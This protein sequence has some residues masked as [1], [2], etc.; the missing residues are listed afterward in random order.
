MD[1]FYPPLEEPVQ[2]SLILITKL[3]RENSDYLSDPSCPYTI[4]FKN[5]IKDILSECGGKTPTGL[6][7]M[8]SE[9]DLENFL[10]GDNLLKESVGLYKEIN[11]Y[12]DRIKQD[13]DAKSGDYNTY[14]RTKSVLLE[15]VID[16]K[17]EAIKIDEYEVFV[18]TLLSTLEEE[19]DKDTL[20][21]VLKKLDVL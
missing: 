10:K 17:K 20:N 3:V 13:V 2:K 14:Y 12:G 1:Y 5:F 8:L 21:K 19:L 4:E 16:M 7:V 18:Q 9:E 6:G 11:V 15:K